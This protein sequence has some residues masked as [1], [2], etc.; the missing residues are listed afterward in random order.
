MVSSGSILLSDIERPTRFR[1]DGFPIKEGFHKMMERPTVSILT[2]TFNH[3]RFIAECI[4]SVLSQTYENWEMIIVDD[5]SNDDTPEIVKRYNDPRIIS[6]RKK[7]RGIDCLGENYNHALRM[8]KGK[9]LLILEGDDFLPRNRIE[10]QLP[11][12]EDEGVVLSHGRYSYAYNKRMVTYPAPFKKDVLNN[13]PLGSA[14]K[15]FLQGFNPIGTQSVMIRKSA[16]FEIGGFA[17]PRYLP[18]VDYPTWMKLALK[19]RFSFIPEVL[20]Y[21]RRHGASVTINNNE[22]IFK[23]FLKYCDEFTISFREEL[24]RLGLD[25]FMKNRGPIA[26]LSLAWIKLSEKKWG[27][28]LVFSKQSWSR[29]EVLGRTFKIKII[30]GMLGAYLHWNIPGLFKSLLGRGFGTQDLY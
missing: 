27:E 15:L 26:Y 1:E 24:S 12:F 25:P 21:W 13:D 18:L 9:Y 10:R 29:K 6:I 14:F 20:G 4:E 5:G 30:V 7:N 22:Q 17:Q 19:G 28:A 16:L 3:E 2:P 23:G 11:S 8:A